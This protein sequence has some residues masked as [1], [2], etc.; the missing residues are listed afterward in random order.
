MERQYLF[1]S[2]CTSCSDIVP[3]AWAR[4]PL[5]NVVSSCPPSKCSHLSWV[6]KQSLTLQGCSKNKGHILFATKLCPISNVTTN[7][8]LSLKHQL[9]RCSWKVSLKYMMN[10]W[11]H[12]FLLLLFLPQSL[13]AISNFHKKMQCF[14]L[15]FDWKAIEESTCTS[16]RMNLWFE[17][18]LWN[19]W[20]MSN[21]GLNERAKEKIAWK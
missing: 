13:P 21:Y 19:M 18:F 9:L 7:F 1:L 3:L 6:I 12:I 14:L 20:Q 17:F 10:K 2:F 8:Y 16:K 11:F 5:E 15:G 4:W